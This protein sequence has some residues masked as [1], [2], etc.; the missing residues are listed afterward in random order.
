MG[1]HVDDDDGWYGSPPCTRGAGST[2]DTEKIT[3][4][5]M[6]G[7]HLAGSIAL[8]AIVLS[9]GTFAGMTLH[10]SGARA[11]STPVWV[12]TKGKVVQLN[13]IAGYGSANSG[14]NFDGAAHG[15]MTITIP[16]GDTVDATFTNQAQG[17]Q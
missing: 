16:L 10:A 7:R 11:A 2:I 1:R 8:G 13:L 15:Q 6:S 17:A 9:A 3:M 5:R 4:M 12:T 14:F